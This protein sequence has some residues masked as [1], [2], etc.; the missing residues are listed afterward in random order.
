[1]SEGQQMYLDEQRARQLI[2]EEWA[3][4]QAAFSIEY[5][6][7]QELDQRLD[8]HRSTIRS[9]I[10]SE[11]GGY[12][13][14]FDSI[15]EEHKTHVSGLVNSLDRHFRQATDDMAQDRRDMRDVTQKMGEAASAVVASLDAYKSQHTQLAQ[16]DATVDNRVDRVERTVD[17]LD[18]R[19]TELFHEIRGNPDDPEAFSIKRTLREEHQYRT[20]SHQD[21][22]E[23]IARI[24]ATQDEQGQ[25]LKR[26]SGYETAA[27]KIGR[28]TVVALWQ[29][30]NKNWMTRALALSPVLVPASIEVIR[31]IVEAI[32]N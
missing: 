6:T 21:L 12:R 29:F 31:I 3:R 28:N 17:K 30:I 26:L 19:V 18:G 2:R 25:T 24:Q 8:N 32:N 4:A 15:L 10:Q 20:K 5:V 1:M 9:D 27:I 13:N 14:K 23:A 16:H 22:M 11:L 7:R